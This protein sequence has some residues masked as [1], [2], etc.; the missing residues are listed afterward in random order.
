MAFYA[1]FMCHYILIYEL[2]QI[3][4]DPFKSQKSR[5]KS[6][7]ISSLLYMTLVG[8]LSFGMGNYFTFTSL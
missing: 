4:K 1:K 6:Y 2:Y 7:I 3:V 8:V 5:I